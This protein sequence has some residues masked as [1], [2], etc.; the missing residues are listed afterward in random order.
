VTASYAPLIPLAMLL[1]GVL[2]QLILAGVLTAR[3]KGW[4]ALLSGVGALAGVLAI[5]P[6]ILA[7]G[8]FDI[9]F[10]HWD[11]P[12]QLAY[13][14]DGLSFL[15]ALMGAGIGSAVL[16]YSV[17]YME[18]E[19]GATRFYSLVLI[20][21]AGLI[22]L[23]YTSDLFLVYLS[24][25]L[26]G[27]CSFFLVGFWYRDSEAAYGA[28][29]VLT[30][31]HLAGYGLFAAVVLI[32]FRTGTTLWTDPK[33]QGAFSTGIF[34]LI[35]VAAVAKSVQFP[36][37]T[38]IPSAMAAPTPVSA[39]LHAACYVKAGVYLVA[40]MHSIGPWPA[41]W[42][43][44]VSWLGAITLLI[45][46]LF[47]LA[48]HDL[49]K[50]LA[51]H[52][53]SQIGYMMLGIGLGTPLG[54]AAGLFHCLN[55]GLFKGGLF[56]CAGAVQHSCGT[57][58]MDKLGGLGRKMP[59]T[60]QIWL[61]CAA[62]IA[63]VPLFNGFVSKWM[64]YNAA[65]EVHQPMLALIPWVGSILTVFSFLKATSGVFLGSEG[66]ATEHAHEVNWTM[67]A[68]G[69]VLAAGCILL[70]V[71]PQLAITYL[72][73]PLLPA[74]G[75]A[76][77]VG[78]S[79]FGLSSGQ[80]IWLAS[81]GLMLGVVALLFGALVVWVPS[82]MRSPATAGGAPSVFT[83][84]EMLPP[85]GHMGAS[86]FSY[87]MK[88]ALAPFYRAFDVDTA[89]LGIWHLLSRIAS[90]IAKPFAAAE[91]Y[92]WVFLPVIAVAL[93]A[94][95]W[96]APVGNIGMVT[97]TAA[98]VPPMLILAVGVGISL[99]GLLLASSAAKAWHRLLLPLA[100]AG[101]LALGG[102]LAQGSLLR[103]GLLEA[104]SVVAL[105]TLWKTSE[106]AAARYGYLLAIAISAVGMIGGTL[107]AEQGN[108]HLALALL[109]PA[110][111]VKLGLVPL[112]LWL[113]PV[114][115]ST[116]AVLAGLVIGVIDVAA[117]AE[118]LTLRI[119]EPWLFTPAL[120]WIVLGVAS[121]VVGALLALAQR[122]IKRLLAF[123]TVE[124]L[125]LV[126]VALAFGGDLGLTG[127][128]IGATV[129]AL[130]KALLFAS[131]SGPE[132][133]GAR[134]MDARGLAS[135]HPLGSVGFAI[136]ALAVLG[137]PPTVGYAAHWRIF[138]AVA[139]NVPLFTALCG[140]AM[141]S[142]AVYARAITLFWWGSDTVSAE[143]PVQYNKIL[144]AV[145]VLLLAITLLAVGVWPRLLGG[146]A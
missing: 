65:L 98:G 117:F 131:I 99:A 51:F 50:L 143:R 37:H 47:A 30:M 145:A 96:F 91:Q 139:G 127:A 85:R 137:V 93:G 4:L 5:W 126:V 80:G 119:S 114:A 61:V 67:T 33:V 100:L 82:L 25:E 74:L 121:A 71:A 144:M 14:I 63:G 38:W 111:A 48:Q 10:G 60:M 7:G 55:H 66:S 64:L 26:V 62:G 72:L 16:L 31:T 69:G 8:A 122:N 77:L 128:L 79:W 81:G 104:A 120:P 112:W 87:A 6:T 95:G 115:E 3:A 40:R 146:V 52:T 105:L 101:G 56:L 36:L 18:K 109:L 106:K 94:F 27:L 68:G 44:T 13:H 84:G 2:L 132:A 113:P 97:A 88:H 42:G 15:F 41:S 83:G 45:G 11:G 76:P 70:G 22:H 136:G 19:K 57:R 9:A 92:A 130:A 58:D 129:H 102:I 141:L 142:V 17:G 53:V 134:L 39:L 49:K 124:D 43:L 123:S 140:A 59:H 103:T 29:K 20:F 35:L 1:G 133:D 23:V 118:V 110:I 86:D 125:G 28:R 116:P 73:N 34:L 32:Y 90:S 21:I 75:C 46:V 138:T 89:W 135:R 12:I 107:A 108:A 78:V 24:W 54:V